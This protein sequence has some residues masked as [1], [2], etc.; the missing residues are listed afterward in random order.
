MWGYIA[1]L[2][3]AELATIGLQAASMALN[4]A[5]TMGIMF[6]IQGIIKGVDY[7]IHRTEK[8]Q[9]ALKS[10][11]SEFNSVTDELKSLGEE[12]DITKKRLEELQKL[13]DNG[14]LSIAKEEEL[15]NLQ[16]T[17]EELARKIALKQQEQAQEARDVL[18]DSK[19]NANS[20]VTSKYDRETSSSGNYEYGV[21]V[22]PDKELEL[23]IKAYED[24]NELAN[25]T[26]DKNLKGW[27]EDQAESAKSRTEEMY[28][29]ISPTINAYEDLINAGIEL[30]GEDKIR[31]EQL[32]K[33]QDA[34]LAYIYA[35]NGTKEA[36]E[37]LNKEQRRNVLINRLTNQGLSK[38]AAE[39]V[40]N[41]ISDEDLNKYWDKNFSFTPPQLTDYATIEE[42]GKAYAEAW[43]NGI[44]SETQNS[45]TFDSFTD[46]WSSLDTTEDENLKDFKKDVLELAEAGRLTKETFLEQTGVET[47]LKQVGL[48][49]EDA[50][51]KINKLVNAEEQ[52]KALSDDI[53]AISNALATKKE[54]KV[55]DVST[56][57]GFN[58][59]IR[60][61]DAWDNFAKLMG[62][63]KSSMEDCQTAANNLATEW[64]NSNNFL[65]NLD[66]TTAQYYTS[67]LKLM[68]IENAE[69]IVAK[70]LNG[71]KEALKLKY[72]SLNAVL[73]DFEGKTSGATAKLL[74]EAEAVGASKQALLELTAQELLFNNSSLDISQKISALNQYAYAA[75][76]VS[77][78]LNSG[79]GL[80]SKYWGDMS[81]EER[82]ATKWKS[83]IGNAPTSVEVSP[84]GTDKDKDKDNNK[85][86]K[87]KEVFDWIEVRLE[88]LSSKTEKFKKKFEDAFTLKGINSSFKK[89]M[90]AIR[91]EIDF[92]EKAAD[93]YRQKANNVDLDPK[94]KKKI[95][96]GTL[97]IESITDKKLKKRIEKYQDFLDKARSADEKVEEL[98][99][100]EI[101][102][103]YDYDDKLLNRKKIKQD[104]IDA[105]SQRLEGNISIKEAK[106][107]SASKKDYEDRIAL[108]KK[109]VKNLKSQNE[110]LISQQEGLKKTS[111]RYQE[112][113][114]EINSNNEAIQDAE[115]SQIEWNNAIN[116]MK[117]DGL[118][119]LSDLLDTI[120]SR[121]DKLKT[122]AELHGDNISNENI[123]KQFDLIDASNWINKGNRAEYLNSIQRLG[124]NAGFSEEQINQMLEFAQAGRVGDI[125]TYVRLLGK[126]WSE[127]GEFSEAINNYADTYNTE[128]DN[129]IEAEELND[130]RWDNAIEKVNKY[131][132]AIQKEKDIKDRI[133]ATEKVIFEL[134][135]AKAN[136][137]KKV[138]N[139]EQWVYTADKEAIQSAQEAFDNNKQ[140]ELINALE[141]L[142]EALEKEKEGTNLYDNNVNPLFTEGNLKDASH[143][144]ITKDGVVLQL[145]DSLPT[146]DSGLIDYNK[147][148]SNLGSMPSFMPQY[149]MPTLPSYDTVRNNS[150]TIQNLEITMPNINDSSTARDMVEGLRSELVNLGTYA[151]QFNWN[152]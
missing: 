74:E 123:D 97:D 2:A 142:T 145:V 149:S 19:K 6:A 73:T 36:F 125:E 85:N 130:I 23:A 32:K 47:F 139:G 151:K 57:Q 126:E 81:I 70:K 68:G 146:M 12:L 109:S 110:L 59:E 8:M 121:F 114:K 91:K 144:I 116:N 67:Q 69:A 141:D 86:K 148:I 55:V 15:K 94:Y 129:A 78:A 82:I 22:T 101:E 128:I 58:E 88:K 152:S 98:T 117:L 5:M 17:N 100:E 133:L 80:D 135:K 122:L 79:M 90:A 60:K 134:E 49:A 77:E 75:L 1:S 61:L 106:G 31:Y 51:E 44:L 111:P 54:D 16:K 64:I 143:A 120:K 105:E 53:S 25:T 43:L 104:E 87:S 39:A 18:K 118:Q 92:N 9:E 26:F 138:W 33:S 132:E 136:L 65:S 13:A 46:A 95:R 27:Y 21:S 56:L 48:S 147:I 20:T 131:I 108:S 83:I 40:V 150:I 93:K 72:Q 35:I 107:L 71:E 11:V 62:D 45:E 7:L 14:T 41:S 50:V 42:Y 140:E 66:D 10:S 63:S 84:D 102:L 76:G 127:L 113:Q 115:K 89:T 99:K 112:L 28:A 119:K 3:K 137:T 29:L 38:S 4:I 37:G 30:E 124:N 103:G 96:N 34:Y 24:N 52:L